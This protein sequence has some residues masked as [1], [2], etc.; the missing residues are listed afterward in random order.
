MALAADR[1]DADPSPD[2]LSGFVSLESTLKATLAAW[3]SAKEK[4]LSPLNAT[5]ANAGQPPVELP[6]KATK[7]D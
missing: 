3:E 7:K 6:T 2:A 5:L 4:E 1:A